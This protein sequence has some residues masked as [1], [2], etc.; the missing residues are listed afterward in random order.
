LTYIDTDVLVHAYVI[1]NVH[2]HIQ[3]GE[4]IE[5]AKNDNMAV[6][7]TLSVQ[8]TLF[9]LDRLKVGAEE[10]YA[11][12]DTLMQLGPLTYALENLRRAVDIAMRVG[13]RNIND[14]IHTAIAESHCTELITY[15]RQDFNRIRNFARVGITI[16]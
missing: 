7:S 6:I 14:C 2:K 4:I 13:F 3:A 12:F 1:Q 15:N 11:T 16:L 8:E 10:I 5:R 9:V